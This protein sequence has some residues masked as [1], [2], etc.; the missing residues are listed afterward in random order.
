M[1]RIASVRTASV[2]N[3]PFLEVT[4]IAERVAKARHGLTG[5]KVACLKCSGRLLTLLFAHR[6]G[7]GIALRLTTS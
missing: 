2:P 5:L 7:R 4:R 1:P 3:I 6:V